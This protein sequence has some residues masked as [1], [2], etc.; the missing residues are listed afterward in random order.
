MVIPDSSE[1]AE[2]HTEQRRLVWQRYWSQG[3]LHSCAGSFAHNYDG[4]IRRF[5]LEQLRT[6]TSQARILDIATG[7]G[8][9]PQLFLNEGG[10]DLEIHAVDCAARV[11]TW[12]DE[13]PQ[14]SRQRLHWHAGSYAERLPFEG[15]W[16]DW[17]TSQ[18][19]IEYASP[20]ARDEL[21]RVLKP[22][23]QCA[24]VLHHRESRLA[25]TSRIELAHLDWL[26][27]EHGL[28]AATHAVLP[29]MTKLGSPQGL[30]EVRADPLARTCRERFNQSMQQAQQRAVQGPVPDVL[31]E[32]CTQ[33]MTLLQAAPRQDWLI[34]QKQWDGL[35]QALTDSR[36]R[37]QELIQCA[38]SEA[39]L[40]DWRGQLSANGQ[41]Q[42]RIEPLVYDNYLIGW[43][44]VCGPA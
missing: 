6:L 16:F 10:K 8:A 3:A 2:T 15:A 21:L 40:A 31:E 20:A 35:H 34:T 26:L 5:W 1:R 43:T 37:H 33:V 4:S 44:L 32:T 13:L 22:Q 28:L 38:L 17:A 25:Q 36:F 42:V 14:A 12:V 23:G 27:G 9:L 18:F 41:R 29:Y 11:P 19:G 24:F 39:D 7:N 30:A